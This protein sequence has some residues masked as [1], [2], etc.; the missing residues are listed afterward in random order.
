MHNFQ[1]QIASS[2]FPI[3][4]SNVFCQYENILLII[5]YLHSPYSLSQLIKMIECRL[6]F[7]FHLTPLRRVFE[8]SNYRPL[9]ILYTFTFL[10]AAPRHSFILFGHWTNELTD[11]SE[12]KLVFCHEIDI[13]YCAELKLATTC[14]DSEFPST[15]IGVKIN[16]INF[17]MLK[18]WH[19]KRVYALNIYTNF[20]SFSL[21]YSRIIFTLGLFRSA[22]K[23]VVRRPR[24]ITE[25]LARW[26]R[27]FDHGESKFLLTNALHYN[28][29]N[30]TRAKLR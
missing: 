27:Q 28:K 17:F 4:S 26:A 30:E 6:K 25:Q 19:Q 11:M 8:V 24:K 5:I 10:L 3:N 29:K 20:S 16:N 12:E 23:N 7:L 1:A 9:K 21:F 13:A 15:C 18:N 2:P 14:F 22:E